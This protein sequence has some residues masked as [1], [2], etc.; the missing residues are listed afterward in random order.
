MIK[1]SSATI[2]KSGQVTLPVSV[3]KKLG[4]K[5]KDKLIFRIEEGTITVEPEQYTLEQT[6]GSVDERGKRDFK[7][8]SR[9]AKGEKAE[10]YN[11]ASR[12]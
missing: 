12:K 5:P 1:E 3:R 6:F 8:M 2:T 9:E 7:K 10:E 11:D 4:V